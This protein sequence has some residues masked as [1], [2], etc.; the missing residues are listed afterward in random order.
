M[1]RACI[2][3]F[4]GAWNKY[5]PLIEFSYNNSYQA[6]I[7]M[8]PYEALYGRRFRSPVHWYKTGEKL[9]STP[10]FIESTTEAVKLIQ[11]RMKTTQCRQKSYADKRRQPLEFEV[12]DSMF[13]KVAPVKGVMQFGKT[14]KLSPRHIGPFEILEKIGKVAYRL[15]LPP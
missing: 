14:R 6:T 7:G 3:E 15:A 8:A 11:E 2:L 9:I 5:L 13:L 4:K 1:L 12:G 10:D